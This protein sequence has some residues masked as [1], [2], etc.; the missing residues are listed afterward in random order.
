MKSS[1]SPDQRILDI[2]LAVAVVYNLIF[3]ADVVVLGQGALASTVAS[4][5]DQAQDNKGI[6]T[7]IEG[8]AVA[9]IFLDFVVRYDDYE[10]QRRQLRLV[11]VI[12][13]CTGFVFKAFAFYLDSSF[14]E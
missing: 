7:W 1:T 4:L 11:A 6:F 5:M 14:L 8:I 3:V 12:I 2:T 13:A 9:A 10:N